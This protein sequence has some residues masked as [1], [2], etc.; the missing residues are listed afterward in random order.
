MKT[1]SLEYIFEKRSSS[2]AIRILS[3]LLF[4][5]VVAGS[6]YYLIKASF[7]PYK[8][9]ALSYLSPLRNTLGIALFYYPLMYLLIPQLLKD[10]AWSR[11]FFYLSLLIFA[12]ILFDAISEKTLFQY[13]EGC[14]AK[15]EQINPAYL[16]VIQ[17]GLIDNILFKGSQIGLF[18][19]L[20]SGILLPFAIKNS[21]GYY[22]AYAQNLQFSK[23]KVQW[24]LNFLKAQV[25]PHFLFNTL[26]NLYG[27]ILK[28]RK[29]QSTEMVTRLSDFMRYSLQNA[30][31]TAIPLKEEIELLNNYIELEKIRLNHTEVSFTQHVQQATNEV[32]P[33]LF[34][35]LLEN[36]FKY[37]SDKAGSEI[38]IT[39]Q[40][41]EDLLSFSIENTYNPDRSRKEKGGFGLRNL[42]RRLELH[43]PE[44]HSLK[45][46][47][48]GSIFRAD[49]KFTFS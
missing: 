1:L 32:P 13:C 30:D 21:L 5:L 43:Y 28:N 6:S 48:N 19:N 42:K 27:S 16:S 40:E 41:Q 9:T 45:T 29:D 22:Q 34:I 17:K 3:H 35:P 46:T 10:K 31:R 26:N 36:A 8:D 44:K 38:K 33:L 39:L 11:F 20:F 15:A 18:L 47:E 2:Q 4:W 23:D 24:E 49:L 12:Y 14:V 7:D 25:N 37:S